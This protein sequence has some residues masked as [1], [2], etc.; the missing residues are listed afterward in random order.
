MRH[1][2]RKKD[3]NSI[4]NEY[5]QNLQWSPSDNIITL[6]LNQHDPTL[7][8]DLGFSYF[9]FKSEQFIVAFMFHNDFCNLLYYK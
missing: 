7:S 4:M 8:A 3:F 2:K 5:N 9:L 1:V 6:L